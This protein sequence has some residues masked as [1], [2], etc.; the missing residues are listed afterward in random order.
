MKN[1]I[2]RH[3]GGYPTIQDALD[4]I[5]TLEDKQLVLSKAIRKLFNTIS[6]ED[7]LTEKDGKWFFMDKE[8]SNVEITYLKSESTNFLQ[9][10]LWKV[11][12]TDVKYQA[13]KRMFVVSASEV[14]ML[15]GKSWVYVLD[16]ITTRLKSLSNG[17]GKFNKK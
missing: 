11:L 6:A 12:S 16:C 3:L 13:N 14:D 5:N 7:I 8:L 9:S 17:I 2:I 1:W 10:K 4:S 15:L